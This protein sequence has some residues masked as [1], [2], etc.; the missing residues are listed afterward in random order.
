MRKKSTFGLLP[1]TWKENSIAINMKGIKV[2]ICISVVSL[3][4]LSYRGRETKREEGGKVT[5]R[6]SDTIMYFSKNNIRKLDYFEN[7]NT[8]LEHPVK[9]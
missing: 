5:T 8:S 4:A 7:V 9:T 3:H 6:T 2:S 1:S